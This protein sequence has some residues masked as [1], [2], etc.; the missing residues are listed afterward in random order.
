MK[1]GHL[2]CFPGMF[3]PRRMFVLGLDIFEHLLLLRVWLPRASSRGVRDRLV[4]G[5]DYN[6]LAIVVN[7]WLSVLPSTR[8]LLT[9]TMATIEAMIAYSSAV[10]PAWSRLS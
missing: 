7:V 5:D 3:V 10:T 9:M 6:V 8:R 1:A 2:V 4:H